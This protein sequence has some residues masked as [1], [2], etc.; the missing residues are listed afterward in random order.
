MVRTPLAA[1]DAAVFDGQG[2]L[3]LVQRTDSGLWA[4]P[5]GAAEVGEPPAHVAEREAAE[6]TGLVVRARRLI[7]IFDNRV[8]AQWES[9][10]HMYHLLFECELLGGEPVRTSE[11]LDFRWVTRDEATT[12]P[13]SR[14]HARKVPVAFRMRDDPHAPPVFD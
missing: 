11:T 3:M 10:V 4:L 6:E 7:G 13:L 12:L 9:P 5:G 2:R 1:A 8:K 14:T